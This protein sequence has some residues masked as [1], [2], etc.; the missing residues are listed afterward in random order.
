M[1][2]LVSIYLPLLL[3]N[4]VLIFFIQP[5]LALYSMYV[6]YSLL[7]IDKLKPLKTSRKLFTQNWIKTF[8]DDGYKVAQDYQSYLLLYKYYKKLP[9]IAGNVKTLVFITIAKNSKFDF[10]SEEI[11]KAMQAVY[12]N[13]KE[14]QKVNKQIT[15]QFKKFD[16]FTDD[17][18]KEV[19]QAIIFKS[20]K[21]RL[22][23]LTVAYIND[24][25]AIYSLFPKKKYPNKFVFFACNEIKR[26]STVK[27]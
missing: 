7:T 17:V 8:T 9:G 20:G 2:T 23:N 1:D 6:D 14:Y 13:N 15:L 11:D 22:I 21:Q 4:F 19:E 18:V 16:E 24:I 10:Y 25:Q 27:E 3:L 5:R 26:I 12:V